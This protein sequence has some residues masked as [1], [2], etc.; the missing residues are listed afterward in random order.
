VSGATRAIATVAALAVL[1]A[2]LVRCVDYLDANYGAEV[3]GPWPDAFP[4]DAP[5]EDAVSPVITFVEGGFVNAS[6]ADAS[7]NFAPPPE[8][9]P[10]DLLVA[11]IAFG[12]VEG[13]A[14]AAP[15]APPGWRLIDGSVAIVKPDV[16]TMWAYEAT[17]PPDGGSDFIVTSGFG[18][19]WTLAL[20][21]ADPVPTAV[22]S[23]AFDGGGDGGDFPTDSVSTA[24]GHAVIAAFA[25]YVYNGHDGA[26]TP[27]WELSSPP[28]WIAQ[29]PEESSPRRSGVA[30]ALRSQE[31]GPVSATGHASL[32]PDAV[33][34]L[35]IDFKPL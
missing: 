27:L 26:A 14:A 33:T 8:A 29:V 1:A 23:K 32:P 5:T 2:A 20:R 25:S 30:G 21:G 17:Y 4:G 16:A 10:G 31:A 19:G 28:V 3:G 18:F 15:A 35:I 13:G 9:Q 34:W 24:A 22:A 12:D 7:W 11:V 6:T